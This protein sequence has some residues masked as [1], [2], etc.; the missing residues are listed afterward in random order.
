MADAL[1]RNMQLNKLPAPRERARH[2]VPSEDE[3]W[4]K[5]ASRQ[6]FDFITR[7]VSDGNTLPEGLTFATLRR[8]QTGA[9]KKEKGE[10][11]Y[12]VCFR[13]D[14]RAEM[15]SFIQQQ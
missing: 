9:W 15:E 10:E 11:R 4:V 8:G 1:L 5:R 14:S 7:L 12:K 13:R 2:I 6:A 3:R